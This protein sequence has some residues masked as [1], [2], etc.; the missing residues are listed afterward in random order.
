[1]FEEEKV[2]PLILTISYKNNRSEKLKEYFLA[3][4]KLSLSNCRDQNC[5]F[6][7]ERVVPRS[8]ASFT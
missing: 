5:L 7:E 8:F 3:G 6:G 1:M 4:L 2:F